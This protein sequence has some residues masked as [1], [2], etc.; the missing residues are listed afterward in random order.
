MQCFFEIGSAPVERA[1][2]GEMGGCTQRVQTAWLLLGLA[3]ESP[4]LALGGPFLSSFTN[5]L[6]KRSSGHVGLPFLAVKLFSCSVG[7][8]IDQKP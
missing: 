3:T 2:Q 4:W 8:T 1:G 5:T 7:V 6:R